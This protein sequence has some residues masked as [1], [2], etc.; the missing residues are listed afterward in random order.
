M[1]TVALIPIKM[2]NERTPG[3]NTKRF[4][5]GTPLISFIQTA[6]LG[7]KE[8]NDIF[9]YCSQDDIC[10]YILKGV[11][12][13][14]RD[15]RFDSQSVNVNEMFYAFSQEVPAD[16]Y[17][18]AH[19]TA[20]FQTSE[21][22]DKGVLAVKSGEYDSAIAVRKMQEFIWKDGKAFNYNPQDIPRTQDLQP[23]FVETTGLY[24]FTKDVIENKKSRIGNNPYMLEVSPIEAVDINHPIDFEMAD[25]INAGIVHGV[26][27]FSQ[28]ILFEAQESSAENNTVNINADK[29]VQVLDCTLRDGGYCNN[30]EF[31][32]KNIKKITCGLVE[33]GVDIIEC[34]FISNRAER[35]AERS[36]YSSVEEISASIP[37]NR[38]S[39]FVAMANLGEFDFERL[40]DRKP[41]M[42]DG[43]RLAFHRKD[44]DNAI[45]AAKEIKRRGYLLF[46]Q[47][48]ISLSY[49]DR[50]FLDLI[51]DCNN[52][53][54]YAFYIVDSF[55]VMK[56]KDLH[57][58]FY[59]V[60]HNLL[61]NIAI[62][63]HSHN[64]M[65]LAYSNAQSLIDLRTRH[66][67]IIDCCVYGMGRGAGNLNTELFVGY[68]NDKIC[69]NYKLEPLLNIID[70]I[71]EP[72]HQKDYWGYSLPNYLSASY[73][74]HPNY[75]G[76]LSDKCTLNV[77]E[78][79]M[80]FGMMEDE[81]RVYF[82]RQYIE[83]LYLRFL[84]KG[85]SNNEKMEELLSL[86]KGKTVLLIAPGK[87]SLTE[88]DRIKN[89]NENA[90]V[91]SIN[92]EYS[93]RKTD[94]IFLSNLRRFREMEKGNRSKCIVTS[95]I[96][97]DMIYLQTDYKELLNDH[98]M[99]QD[100]AGL[101]AIKFLIKC[102]VKAIYIAGMD[103]Y[104]QD[105]SGNY[106]NDSVSF[107]AARAIYN[108]LN[109]G[110]SC[111]LNEYAKQVNI[112]FLTSE[113]YV[114]L[115]EGGNVMDSQSEKIEWGGVLYRLVK[116]TL[117]ACD[118][119]GLEVAA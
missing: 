40:P 108:E 87:S 101:M 14:R 69:S 26:G 44:K 31:G 113:R 33:A 2:N 51:N 7:C 89:F 70:E 64:N 61:Q 118:G 17:V 58:L 54:P 79:N 42:I 92:C 104:S 98:E 48:M 20:P 84:S 112:N 116:K 13:L 97:A 66:R 32:W 94:F 115:A 16:I 62:G 53:K 102:G 56:P 59:L 106:A 35:N 75:A 80:I 30:W 110:I 100:N 88:K 4:M 99:V 41:G 81:K 43:I 77:E 119:H 49:S 114:H 50:E 52:L 29:I 18:L 12:F 117:F 9:V 85:Q 109:S 46:M 72:F 91:I 60:E 34:G 71:L 6:L 25:A 24:I 22:I 15:K 57:R 93:Y 11:N 65:Q 107:I 105:I 19:A 38:E 55:G 28:D 90:I 86:L 27:D 83:D 74:T 3:K 67:I 82:D 96:P 39:V 36:I 68:L 111:V 8:V 47:P 23:L 73:N 76:Y 37:T 10:E 103:G 78:M 95:N 45:K 63:F 21:T 1:R 5:D